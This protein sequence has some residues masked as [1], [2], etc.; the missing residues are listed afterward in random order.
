MNFLK[1]ITSGIMM[2]ADKEN[3]ELFFARCGQSSKSQH[4]NGQ[5]LF[6]AILPHEMR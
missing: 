1:E 4:K 6:L 2:P 3:I 5:K